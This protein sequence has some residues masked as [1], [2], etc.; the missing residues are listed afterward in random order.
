MSAPQSV[1]LQQRFT[2]G[3]ERI[4]RRLHERVPID[5][6][7]RLCW[8]DRQGNHI[9]RARAMDLSQFGMLVEAERALE[10]GTIVAV[11]TNAVMLGSACV[12]YC[13]P[14]GLK[15]RIGMHVPDHRRALLNSAK[16]CAAGGGG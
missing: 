9:L 4:N 3:N 7:V 11:E 5:C 1:P 6:Q 15:Y 8:Q 13:T 10:P 12:R 16:A 14:N 2:A